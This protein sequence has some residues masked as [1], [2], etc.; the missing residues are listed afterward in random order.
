MRSA[1]RTGLRLFILFI[2]LFIYCNEAWAKGCS[3]HKKDWYDCFGIEDKSSQ[4][5][6]EKCFNEFCKQIDDIDDFYGKF[7]EKHRKFSRGKWGHRLFFHWGFNMNPRESRVF[8]EQ[9]DRC[10]LSDEEKESIWQDVITEQSHRNTKMIN[11]VRNTT[12]LPREQSSALAT[13][14]YDIHILGDYGGTLLEPLL[15]P[16]KIKNDIKNQGIKRLK[17]K[18][19]KQKEICSELDLAGLK[20]TD[21]KDSA[22][23]ILEILRNEMPQ[24]LFGTYGK[25]L[26]NNGIKINGK[27]GKDGF[28]NALLSRLGF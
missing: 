13:I 4:D 28:W 9:L 12:G 19:K 14:I 6:L 17:F 20:G 21:E 16:Y 1:I 7:K 3:G 23:K 24:L 22:R 15:E 18:L 25:T 26:E 11:A 27:N 5:V 8:K 2:A 10:G